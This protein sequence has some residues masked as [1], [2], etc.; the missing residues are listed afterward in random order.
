M[1]L[2][3][4]VGPQ[5]GRQVITVLVDI[6]VLTPTQPWLTI[7]GRFFSFF[8][9]QETTLAAR[10]H[11]CSRRLRLFCDLISEV[12]GA[13]SVV[14]VIVLSGTALAAPVCSQLMISQQSGP[15]SGS[16]TSCLKSGNY[17]LSLC[18]CPDTIRDNYL[19]VST[20]FLHLSLDFITY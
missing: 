18:P 3:A 6:P 2:V 8:T 20:D 7:C 9:Q 12:Q 13:D 16:N 11:L 4:S 17:F 14:G 10:S 5:R 19:V 15:V 1:G